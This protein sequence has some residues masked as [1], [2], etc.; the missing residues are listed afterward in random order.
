MSSC[1]L[2]QKIVMQGMPG[3]VVEVTD[4]TGTDDHLQLL[5][6][7]D[8]FAGRA[9]LEQH[10]MVM[11]LLRESLREKVHAVKIKTMTPEKYQQFKER[12]K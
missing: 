10:Q 4:L 11:D 7:S 12:N 5:V 2:V 3:A 8:S 1:D 6:V 9:L